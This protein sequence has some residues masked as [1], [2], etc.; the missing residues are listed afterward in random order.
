MMKIKYSPPLP[1][2]T[3][4]SH[5]SHPPQYFRQNLN[6]CEAKKKILIVGICPC[7]NNH[8]TVDIFT[9][10]HGHAQ[11]HTAQLY[12]L[13]WNKKWK[14]FPQNGM[15]TTAKKNGNLFINFKSNKR[16]CP[17]DKPT[18]HSNAFRIFVRP[19][20]MKS[21][22]TQDENIIQR[23]LKKKKSGKG[24]GLLYRQTELI[25]YPRFFLF[26]RLL[27]IRPKLDYN[28]QIRCEVSLLICKRICSD[29]R[30]SDWSDF[31]FFIFQFIFFFTIF[32]FCFFS[33][34]C[35]DD[36]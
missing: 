10:A 2:C 5:S 6:R 11:R 28:T 35:G 33:S 17:H 19:T 4:R 22:L 29:N 18:D 25:R 13:F 12:I 30:H 20:P 32:C 27:L 23:K 24:T 16:T 14:N 36:V 7:E 15:A 3:C 8:F 31:H 9:A 34:R 21:L 26:S 1:R